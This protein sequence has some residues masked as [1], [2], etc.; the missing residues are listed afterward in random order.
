MRHV[1]SADNRNKVMTSRRR[2]DVAIPAYFP[3]RGPAG[4]RSLGAFAM[5]VLTLLFCRWQKISARQTPAGLSS[6]RRIRVLD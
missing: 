3:A 5:I 4:P 2:C 6:D 1:I